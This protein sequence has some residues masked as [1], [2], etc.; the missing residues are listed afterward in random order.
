MY[1][2]VLGTKEAVTPFTL[3]LWANCHPAYKCQPRGHGSYAAED[4][5]HPLLAHKGQYGTK[6]RGQFHGLHD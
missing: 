4:A 6:E 2:Y 1:V 3:D 5:A